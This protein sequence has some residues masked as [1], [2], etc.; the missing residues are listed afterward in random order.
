[1]FKELYVLIIIFGSTHGSFSVLVDWGAF[2][3]FALSTHFVILN[4]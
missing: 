4:A 2:H 3:K 1:M